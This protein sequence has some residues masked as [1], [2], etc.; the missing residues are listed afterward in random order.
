MQPEREN[1]PTFFDL[2]VAQRGGANRVP[3]TIARE[4]DFTGAEQG[5]TPDPGVPI[6]EGVMHFGRGGGE[7]RAKGPTQASPGQVRVF[8]GRRPGTWAKS[9]QSP[10]RAAHLCRKGGTLCPALSGL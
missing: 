5:G 3:E 8:R 6:L 10:E 2:A 1:Q 7:S 4:V 9:Q